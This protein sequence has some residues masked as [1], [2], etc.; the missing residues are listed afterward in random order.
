MMR[1]LAVVLAIG[2]LVLAFIRVRD[3]EAG[4]PLVRLKAPGQEG[5]PSDQLPKLWPA[6]GFQLTERREQTVTLND[7]RGKVWVADFFYTTCPGPCPAMTSRLSEIHKALAAEPDV[8]LLSI[9]V[10]PEKDTPA[11]LRAY[12][13]RF[14]ASDRWLFLTGEKSHIYQI[15]RTGFK[16]A[17]VEDRAAAEPIT[18]STRMVLV[19][20]TST[21][22]GFYEILDADGGKRLVRDVK[23]LLL[24]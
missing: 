21:V 4:D 8:R 13:E 17:V 20:R 18:H 10:D 24:E 6:P 23:R 1:V 16:M 15:A 2:V 7:L 12:A 5:I 19:D 3:R 14:G 9:S 22:R 11:M